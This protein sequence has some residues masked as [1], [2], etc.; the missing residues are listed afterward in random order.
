MTHDVPWQRACNLFVV[1]HSLFESLKEAPNFSKND[2][3][4]FKRGD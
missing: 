3:K 1:I 4:L 2:S